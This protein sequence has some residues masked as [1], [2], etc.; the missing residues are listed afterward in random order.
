MVTRMQ[1]VRFAECDGKTSRLKPPIDSPIRLT[2]M[3][4]LSNGEP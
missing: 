3:S 1:A 2:L 4:S